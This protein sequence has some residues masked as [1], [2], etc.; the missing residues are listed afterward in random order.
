MG[1]DSELLTIFAS[2][3][4]DGRVRSVKAHAFPS[5]PDR[6]RCDFLILP[7]NFPVVVMRTQDQL[8]EHVVAETA[9]DMV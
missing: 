8:P 3:L 1:P 9:T 7:A 2:L 6:V 4:L 5:R